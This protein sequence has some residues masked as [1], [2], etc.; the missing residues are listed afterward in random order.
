MNNRPVREIVTTVCILLANLSTAPVYA[1]WDIP[2]SENYYSPQKYHNDNYGD[3]VPANINEKLF[4]HLIAGDEQET[5]KT[6]E[7]N[8]PVV[9]NYNQ[10]ATP[11]DQ[12]FAKPAPDYSNQYYQRPVPA[13][14]RYNRERN[15]T[16]PGN[17]GYNRNANF[18][19]PGN[20]RTTL[21]GPWNNNGSSFNGPWNNRGSGFSSP[22]NNNGSNFNMPGGNNNDSSFSM[23][24]G[25]NNGSSFNP[26]GNGDN[27]GW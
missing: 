1:N 10:T 20:N 25:N 24:W 11:V 22:W 8:T 6:Q 5:N 19:I 23:P 7:T 9:S 3:F 4:G 15:I 12:Q 27:W 16:P 17:Q 26:M 18:N 2:Q 13:D 21:S 14:N